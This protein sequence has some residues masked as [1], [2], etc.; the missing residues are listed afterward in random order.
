V[1]LGCAVL[2]WRRSMTPMWL[3]TLV[4]GPADIGCFVFLD[5]PG[6]AYFMQ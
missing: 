3:A 2:I 5:L 1:T 4:G 6:Y